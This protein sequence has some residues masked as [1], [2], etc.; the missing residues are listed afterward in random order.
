MC[1]VARIKMTF[2]AATYLIGVDR[3]STS[4][5]SA[6]GDIRIQRQVQIE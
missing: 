2:Y 6:H 4:F 3:L 1:L 5:L